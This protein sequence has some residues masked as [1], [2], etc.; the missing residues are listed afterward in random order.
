MHTTRE[1][2]NSKMLYRYRFLTLQK[3]LTRML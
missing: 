1:R 2:K 3:E